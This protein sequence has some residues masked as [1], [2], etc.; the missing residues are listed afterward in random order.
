MKISIWQQWQGNLLVQLIDGEMIK[1]S[2]LTSWRESIELW[3]VTWLM[4]FKFCGWF[5]LCS[6]PTRTTTTSDCPWPS[7]LST[8]YQ[9]HIPMEPFISWDSWI[10]GLFIAFQL[11]LTTAW[12]WRSLNVEI[13]LRRGCDDPNFLLMI[14]CVHY[15]ALIRKFLRLK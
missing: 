4:L 14:I 11:L 9:G 12:L 10:S 5:I 7:L 8:Q 13:M 1:F 15:L 3:T 2:N 6:L